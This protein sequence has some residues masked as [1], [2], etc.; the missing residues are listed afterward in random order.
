MIDKFLQQL[1]TRCRRLA[2]S[3]G[4]SL[5]ELAIALPILLGLVIGIFEF[6]RAWNVRQVTT[7]AAREGARLA[8]ISGADPLVVEAQIEGR[9]TDA[10]LDP[11]L[12]TIVINGM[13]ALCVGLPVSVQV[14]YPVQFNFIGPIVD[15]LGGGGAIPG[16]INMTTT[17]TMRHE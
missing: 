7:N 9:L 14:D 11:G 12:A 17:S 16:T 10:G 15:L 5:V 8:V 3:S 1:I 2:C 6:G 4:Q 13:C